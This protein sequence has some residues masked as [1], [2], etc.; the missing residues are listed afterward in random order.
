VVI[1]REQLKAIVTLKTTYGEQV[2]AI[3]LHSVLSGNFTDLYPLD[4]VTNPT[5]KY[6]YDFRTTVAQDIDG[7]FGVSSIG[8]PNGLVN[9]K[10]FGGSTVVG[11]TTWTTHVGTELSTPQV[12]DIQLKNFWTPAD[13]SICSFYF[14]EGMADLTSN[15]KIGMYLVED[16][17]IQWQ[18]DYNLPSPYDI[19]FYV[20]RHILRASLNGSWGTKINDGSPIIS[21]GEYIDGYSIKI[22][23][24]KWDIDHLYVVAFVYDAATYEVLQAE[25]QK[26]IP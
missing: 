17:I 26:V 12:V 23:P 13:S 1:V 8:L 22:D 4:T 25:E 18:K 20:H 21:G 10:S 19:Q 5:Q 6:V 3:G 11:Y 16:S 14:V 15:Y 2:I 24:S 7:Y 9:R